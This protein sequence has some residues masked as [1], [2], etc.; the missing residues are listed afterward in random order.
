V[1]KREAHMQLEYLLG[2]K[3]REITPT[4]IPTGVSSYTKKE[5]STATHCDA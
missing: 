3:K 2:S 5:Y 4:F 1:L